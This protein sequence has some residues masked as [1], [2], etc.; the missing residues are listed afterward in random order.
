MTRFRKPSLASRLATLYA[1]LLGV[2][3]LLV[4]FAS[5]IALVVELAGFTG[6]IVIAK[7]REARLLADEYHAEGLTL[8]Q[9]APKIVTALSG[10]GLRIAVFD[11]HGVFLAGDKTLRPPILDRVLAGKVHLAPRGGAQAPR[12]RAGHRHHPA[13]FA[14]TAVD[15]GYVA[16]APS[17][18]LLLLWLI[19]YWRVVATIGVLA[20]ALSWFVGQFFARQALEPIAQVTASLRSLAGGDFTRRRF[21]AAGGDEIA[22]LTSAYNDA[23]SGVA[24][25]IEER[26]MTEDR[27]RQFVADAGHELR[28]PLT[29]IGGYIDVLRRGA[30]EEPKVARQILATMALEKEHMRSLIDRLMRLARLDSEAPPRAE[31]ID[32]AD[33][34]RSQCEAARRLDEER[35]IDYSV[36][37]SIV[38]T[39]DR[40]ELGEA[41]WNVVENAIKYAPQAPIHLR[42]ECVDGVTV[43]SVRDDGPGMTEAERLHA[44]E[45]FY[46]G[47]LRGEIAGSGLGLAIAQRA[48][49]RAGGT[50]TIE[51]APGR[52]TT[53]KVV[54]EG[55]PEA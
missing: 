1:T 3:I 42:A 16:F 23:A 25:A 15:G 47:E 2:T 31:R 50:M 40:S 6:D 9:A 51:S 20:I 30:V 48:V 32:V 18:G 49:E 55:S 39:G 12:G 24:S 44:F 41:I 26:R 54:I 21:I 37:G 45:R 14:L 43:I 34:L 4:V 22:T 28:T 11:R 53:V 52:G 17:L 38:I 7:H 46:R 8:R 36:D 29:V 10:I 19:P 13:P 5:S 33:L 35:A 27:M